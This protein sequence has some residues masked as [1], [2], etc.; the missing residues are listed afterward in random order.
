MAKKSEEMSPSKKVPRESDN[1]IVEEYKE[2]L[3][4]KPGYGIH[5]A[6]DDEARLC[7]LEGLLAGMQETL[8]D[9]EKRIKTIESRK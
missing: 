2:S 1:P 4:N 6:A 9:L 8:Q 5:P 3:L 7:R